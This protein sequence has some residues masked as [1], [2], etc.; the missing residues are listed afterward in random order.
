MSVGDRVYDFLGVGQWV[1]VYPDGKQ[2]EPMGR[3]VAEG[4]AQIFGGR[5]ERTDEQIHNPGLGGAR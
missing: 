2:S 3:T 1:V 4:Y 5:V